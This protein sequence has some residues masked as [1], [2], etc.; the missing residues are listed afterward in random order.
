IPCC[1]AHTYLRPATTDPLSPKTPARRLRAVRNTGARVSKTTN[2]SEPPNPI[3]TQQPQAIPAAEVLRS[4]PR[5]LGTA[6]VI[7]LTNDDNPPAQHRDLRT[8]HRQETLER[9]KTATVID[10]TSDDNPSGYRWER[11][12]VRL[13]SYTLVP[14]GMLQ[15]YTLNCDGWTVGST[16]HVHPRSIIEAVIRPSN[17]YP[18]SFYVTRE[19]G[20]C[21]TGKCR[22]DG[23]VTILVYPEEIV[24]MI[25]QPWREGGFIGF[26]YI[27]EE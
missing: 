16:A 15:S 5:E 12:A 2:M 25:Q 9:L 14:N 7:D 10:L 1:S 23:R 19:E 3:A 17:G 24:A 8:H 6:T 18:A 22:E 21:F 11:L 13:Q 26:T 27:P 4:Q 20:G